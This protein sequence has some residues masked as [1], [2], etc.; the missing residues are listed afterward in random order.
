MKFDPQPVQRDA[1]GNIV[2]P[3]STSTAPATAPSLD[4]ITIR[5]VANGSSSPADDAAALG[6]TGPGAGSATADPSD[7]PLLW[8]SPGNG[9][10]RP[11]GSYNDRVTRS[12]QMTR[13]PGGTL[14]VSEAEAKIF[15]DDAYRAKVAAE[16]VS[17]GL[18]QPEEINNLG[19][20]QAAWNRVV[21]QAAQFYLAGN[22]RTP[23]EVIRLI[24]IQK[25]A[26]AAPVPT[27]TTDNTT[28]VQNFDTSAPTDIRRA[29][30]N[31]L[32]RAPTSQE[33]QS[34]QAGLNSAAQANPQQQQTVTHDDGKGNVTRDVTQSG[35]IDP[36]EVIGQMAQADP[37]YGAYQA[38][39]TY[40]DALRQAIQAFV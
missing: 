30:Q 23:E 10:G 1:N 17:A 13:E 24:N 16:M 28:Q 39:T 20:I 5:G 26:K 37:E 4:G 21:G 32:G 34:Y 7:P 3:S 15:E 36:T 18:L 11:A 27:T 12:P 9:K 35:G 6:L 25:K 19:A 40:M 29:L 31:M 8:S 2:I 38:S 33:M 14:K 22:G